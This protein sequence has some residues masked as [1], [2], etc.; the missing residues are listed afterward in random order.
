MESSD[1]QD[2]YV[3]PIKAVEFSI[4]MSKSYQ[5]FKLYWTIMPSQRPKSRKRS[6]NSK[7]KRSRRSKSRVSRKK[8]SKTRI[9][10][11]KN[12]PSLGNDQKR[13][14]KLKRPRNSK[15]KQPRRSKSRGSK[16]KT[17]TIATKNAPIPGSNQKRN[18]K[19]KR[20]RRS[21]SLDPKK[22]KSKTRTDTK[23][24]SKHA[25]DKCIAEGCQGKSVQGK[26]CCVSHQRQYG[27][28]RPKECPIC[29]E[30]LGKK[31]TP[32]P[33][34]HYAHRE[35]I[36]QGMKAECP[37][38]RDPLKLTPE[39][40]R[41]INK[42]L[43]DAQEERGRDIVRALMAGELALGSVPRVPEEP[44]PHISDERLR[45][46]LISRNA[47]RARRRRLYR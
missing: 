2:H 33:C 29:L 32:W 9:S 10:A 47:A 13:N 21:K 30:K 26:R 20:S 15:L 36:T 40:I 18:P 34:G 7:L 45:R 31:E 12:A 24:R 42:N 16:K 46:A 3:S 1:F 37:L 23:K 27:L 19:L 38:C 28:D 11:T 25:H 43:K 6:K 39:E 44:A 22:K 5:L 35:C 41:K 8:K 17:R 14:S 4:G